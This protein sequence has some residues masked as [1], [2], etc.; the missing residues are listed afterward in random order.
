LSGLHQFV[1]GRNTT[2]SNGDD[3]AWRDAAAS[4]RR[5]QQM[6]AEVVRVLREAEQGDAYEITLAE[7]GGL[8]RRRVEPHA[9][10][11]GVALEFHSPDAAGLDNYQANLLSLILANLVENAVQASARGTTV[12]LEIA[13]EEDRLRF[14]VADE[15]GGLPEVVREHLFAPC[16]SA[17]EGGTGIGLVISKQLA[18]HL[19]ADL[20]LESSSARGTVFVLEL[21][22]RRIVA[23]SPLDEPALRS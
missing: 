16:Q 21:P 11:A 9:R 1:Q 14:R 8:I 17:R 10:E 15:G 23:K 19:G 5:M 6:V 20:L 7:L 22:L 12:K 4:T 13:R 3:P 2:A 18:H